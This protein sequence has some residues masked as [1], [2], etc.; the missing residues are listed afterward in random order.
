MGVNFVES[1]LERL[2]ETGLYRKLRRV[3]GDQGSTLLLDGRE[4][5][6]FSS[7]NYLGLANHPALGEAAKAAID[8][9]GCGSGASRL[10]SGNMTLHEELESKIAE[11]KG[12][13]AALVFNSGFQLNTGVVS[14]LV[15]E[16]DAVFSDALNHASIVDGCRLSRAKVAVYGHLDMNHLEGELKRSSSARRKLIVTESLFSMDGDEAPLADIVGL[17]QRHGAMVMVDEAHAT[18]VYEPNGAGLIAKLGLGEGVFVQMG[19]LGKALGGFGAYIAGSKALRDLL[20]NRCRSFIFTT[21]LPPA[22]MAMTIA[23]IGLVER[24]PERRQALRG[25]SAALRGGLASLGYVM[26]GSRSQ[27]LPLIVGDAQR[28]MKLSQ[29]LLDRGVFA[30]GIRPPTVPP[31]TSRLRITLMA[32]HTQPQLAQA[33]EIF[34]AAKD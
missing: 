13:E 7:N 34:K 1:E 8:R 31:G 9:Y 29:R 10:I 30:Q 4:V 20:I 6:N 32:T 22:V 28:C 17:A 15:G 23:A 11:F 19:T 18:G 33:L 24:E 12:T 26:G 14:T 25:N 3:D 16:G 5:I 27:I 2:K 21:S